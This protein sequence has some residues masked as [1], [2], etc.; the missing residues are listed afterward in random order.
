L[1]TERNQKKDTM[2]I[3]RSISLTVVVLTAWPLSEGFTW[4]DLKAAIENTDTGDLQKL[5]QD[6]NAKELIDTLPVGTDSDTPNYLALHYAC[7]KGK[8]K[9]LKMMLEA[10]ANKDVTTAMKETPLQV[11][12]TMGN[13]K[14]VR[15]LLK[16]G[17]NVFAASTTGKTATSLAGMKFDLKVLREF[18]AAGGD[19]VLALGTP[20]ENGVNPMKSAVRADKL[21]IVRFLLFE[22][23]WGS[24]PK[25]EIKRLVR[26]LKDKAEIG[27][28]PE[29]LAK[30]AEELSKA[31]AELLSPERK[32][33]FQAQEKELR[34]KTA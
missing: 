7:S 9:H 25:D 20:D 26:D 5:L 8:T 28:V 34:E 21:D 1:P 15:A 18:R 32:A 6:S 11:A 24:L 10:G 17:A 3:G 33:Y 27:N 23:G 29:G 19:A 13:H 16:A 4:R 31:S 14:S 2:L 22:V 30:A 12:S